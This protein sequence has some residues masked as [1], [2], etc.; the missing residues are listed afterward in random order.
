MNRREKMYIFGIA[1]LFAL[2]VVKSFILDPAKVTDP[3]EL[4]FA[5][6]VEQRIEEDYDGF[7]YDNHIVVTRLVSV[8]TKTEDGEELY[9]GK[10]RRY[11]LGV[12]PMSDRYIKENVTNFE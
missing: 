8:K 3:N 12:V 10:V 11:F 6:W 1:V 5:N 9:V 7:L 2:L 4:E